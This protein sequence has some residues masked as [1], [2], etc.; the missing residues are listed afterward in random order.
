[1]SQPGFFSLRA[2]RIA[3]LLFLFTAALSI[4]LYDLTDLPL[5]FHPTRQLLSAIKARALYFETQP[6]GISTEKL[7][8]GIR[9]AKLKAQVEPV[10]FEQL[11]AYTYRFTG[12]QLWVAR[13]YSSLF[14]LI[15]GI[16]LFVLVR[17]LASFEA[18]FFSTSYYLFFPY[19]VIASR[20]FQPDPLMVMVILGFWWIF[21]RWVDLTPGP[22]LWDASRSPE[23][24]GR[25]WGTALLAGL[26]GGLAIFIKFSAV[27]FVIGA[28]LGLGRSRFT[29]REL[30]RNSQVWM[31]AV[32]GALPALMYL[33]HGIFIDGGLG[34]QFSGRFMPALLLNPFNYLQWM[35][36]VD[37][38]AGGLFIMLALLGF[39]LATDRRLRTF[40]FGLWGAYLLYGLFF[41]YHVATH[42]YY[43]LPLIPIVAVSLAPLGG[44]FFARLTESTVG[45]SQRSAAY[46]ILILGLFMVVWNVRNQMKAVD[47]RP[48]AGMWAEI[49]ELVRGTRVLALTEN[50]GSRL[51]Y[52]GWHTPNT[53]P[54]LGEMSHSQLRGGTID[55]FDEM[56]EGYTGKRDLFLVT[57]FDE[58]KAQKQLHERLSSYQIYAEGEGYV[59]YDLRK[60]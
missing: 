54:S 40:L 13:V 9:Q 4:R 18:A 8:T 58:W 59:I 2:I 26:L 30:L 23:R 25:L 56:F 43:H 28:A 41:D 24:R 6:D 1:M 53:W 44:W 45:R 10:V 35:T 27:F 48:D 39:F 16:F 60:P 20:S 49:G 22:S 15:G 46:I 36:K 33:I 31:M 38:S 52:W 7:E 47:Y 19:A 21:S 5:D 50:Y 11:V 57:D 55:S 29:W 37:M 12:E 51:E 34:G 3:A 14:W 42:D 17:D 32:V